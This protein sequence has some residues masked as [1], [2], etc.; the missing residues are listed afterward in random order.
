MV[1]GRIYPLRFPEFCQGEK[2]AG[3]KKNA[4]E[5]NCLVDERLMRPSGTAEIRRADE[6]TGL[7]QRRYL[8][9]A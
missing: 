9:V 7:D 5:V 6:R 1:V 4:D 2:V 3:V 8:Q